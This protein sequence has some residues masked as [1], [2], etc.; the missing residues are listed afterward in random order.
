M[1][2]IIAIPTLALV[3]VLLGA[4]G[5]GAT[6]TEEPMAERSEAVMS[7]RADS[8][9]RGNPNHRTWVVDATND[10]GGP[11]IRTGDAFRLLKTG[12][13]YKLKPL[14]RLK[15]RWSVASSY[16]ADLEEITPELL[17][18]EVKNNNHDPNPHLLKI[19]LVNDEEMELEFVDPAVGDC[20]SSNTHGGTAH[21]QN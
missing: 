2:N 4:S 7:A 16:E 6:E 11:H 19:L 12:N 13:H 8:A 15:G 3:S 18:G 5:L 21:A 14:N 17:C 9:S 10:P 20:T 1:K